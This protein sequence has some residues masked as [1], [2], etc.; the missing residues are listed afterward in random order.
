MS[1]IVETPEGVMHV[2]SNGQR[3]SPQPYYTVA[4]V[5]VDVERAAC[6]YNAVKHSWFHSSQ[7]ITMGRSR[8]KKGHTFSAVLHVRGQHSMDSDDSFGRAGGPRTARLASMIDDLHMS[9]KVDRY[10]VFDPQTER[11][12]RHETAGGRTP[13]AARHL[14]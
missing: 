7:S 1:D 13:R 4:N 2:A 8:C 9:P 14:G 3:P 12:R 6:T 5:D 10:E 11:Q